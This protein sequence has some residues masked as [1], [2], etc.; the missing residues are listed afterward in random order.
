M[1]VTR[2]TGCELRRV[3][4]ARPSGAGVRRLKAQTPSPLFA[5]RFSLRI[6]SVDFHGA[7]KSCDG[8]LVLDAKRKFQRRCP[9]HGPGVESPGVER[10]AQVHRLRAQV[11]EPGERR[12]LPDAPARQ[13][14]G[15]QAARAIE[16][17]PI[18]TTCSRRSNVSNVPKK[19]V[20]I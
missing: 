10:G 13:L 4:P 8:S 17:G 3:H 15:G 19:V 14:R 5:L 2:S 16:R 1:S 18:R 9:K 20:G 7:P 6:R 11:L 12:A